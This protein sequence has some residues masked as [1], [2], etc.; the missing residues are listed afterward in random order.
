MWKSK[1][2]VQRMPSHTS[3][4]VLW[5]N[6]TLSLWCLDLVN[7]YCDLQIQASTK[8]YLHGL[9]L[10]LNAIFNNFSVIS[11]RSVLLV[12]ETRVPGE[13]HRDTVIL[14]ELTTLLCSWLNL[15][16]TMMI[17]IIYNIISITGSSEK[18]YILLLFRQCGIIVRLQ[19]R[20]YLV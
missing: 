17:R 14:F 13:H 5:P 20:N 9:G 8:D 2:K 10:L 11:W 4:L 12:K 18:I 19:W 1:E 7:H 15:H 6:N 3:S 16:N